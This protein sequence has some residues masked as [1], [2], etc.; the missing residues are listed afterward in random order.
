M[1]VIPPSPE[2]TCAHSACD[3]TSFQDLE[4][5]TVYDVSF[6]AVGDKK[7]PSRMFLFNPD[8][9]AIRS[10]TIQSVKRHKRQTC[11]GRLGGQ[12]SSPSST[13][14]PYPISDS[15]AKQISRAWLDPTISVA[16][17]PTEPMWIAFHRLVVE[18]ELKA[19]QICALSD[20]SGAD[21][22]F[23]LRQA[24]EGLAGDYF[25]I[26]TK[27]RGLRIMS[28]IWHWPLC[29]GRESTSDDT[30]VPNIDKQYIFPQWKEKTPYP[31]PLE[32]IYSSFL[33]WNGN[34]I[35]SP[36]APTAWGGNCSSSGDSSSR[37][38]SVFRL[39]RAG[40]LKS[41]MCKS[42]DISSRAFTPI[43]REPP[44]EGLFC[45]QEVEEWKQ[46]VEHYSTNNCTLFEEAK[47]PSPV[48][49]SPS[50]TGGGRRRGQVSPRLDTRQNTCTYVFVVLYNDTNIPS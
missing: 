25:E 35:S 37:T 50:P 16:T 36:T 41:P 30:L 40:S 29:K 18:Y 10:C 27:Y 15:L 12:S 48:P 49:M 22:T 14:S 38:L 17:P 1:H 45:P 2:P 47:N 13:P 11:H 4:E 33:L 42:E 46:V 6:G 43:S 5:C 23:I 7:A 19:T 21:C 24:K 28:K 34:D 20:L 3:D 8:E 39:L 31:A 9:F 32:H 26:M 44:W